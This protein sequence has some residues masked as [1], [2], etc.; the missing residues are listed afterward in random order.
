MR[1]SMIQA[2]KLLSTVWFVG[3]SIIFLFLL[4]QTGFTFFGDMVDEVWSWFLPTTVPTLSL[5]IGVLYASTSNDHV[6]DKTIDRFLFHFALIL[7]IAY[8]IV[9][10]L[11]FI[12]QSYNFRHTS[13]LNL[14]K[15]SHLWLAPFQGFVSAAIGAFFVS[16][17][18]R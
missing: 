7:S 3:F 1:I 11:T 6:T 12:M 14:M 9:V 8:L 13:S 15:M 5:I 10:G 17:E 16:I 2:R 4:L 18:K